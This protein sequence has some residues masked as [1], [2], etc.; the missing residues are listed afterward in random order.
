MCRLRKQPRRASMAV[1]PGAAAGQRVWFWHR[2]RRL[3]AERSSDHAR[4]SVI[5]DERLCGIGA[6]A[7]PLA[8]SPQLMQPSAHSAPM[9][10][11]Q[12]PDIFS[13][14]DL[15]QC[16]ALV[17]VWL[18]HDKAKAWHEA[19]LTIW[20]DSTFSAE[21]TFASRTYAYTAS[22]P[23]QRTSCTHA[24]SRVK[25]DLTDRSKVREKSTGY[26]AP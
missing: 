4:T 23:Q 22:V 16:S 24:K 5:C 26:G 18:W 1:V 15:A 3:S 11:D 8:L 14:Y 7:S 13:L 10:C 19:C 9:R 12:R 6:T 2:P 21:G 25:S 20:S 17:A